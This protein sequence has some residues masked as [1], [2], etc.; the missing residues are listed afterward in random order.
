MHTDYFFTIK[1]DTLHSF[2][3]C[4]EGTTALILRIRP[5]KTH[6]TSKEIKLGGHYY[7]YG[8]FSE[9]K[10]VKASEKQKEAYRSTFKSHPVLDLDLKREHPLAF[11]STRLG[12][13]VGNES[14][15][16][17]LLEC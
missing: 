9:E 13:R 5:I 4:T 3:P 16:W 7:I 8:N 10:L 17:I 2:F 1:S 12:L 15:S 14:E 6:A 11:L